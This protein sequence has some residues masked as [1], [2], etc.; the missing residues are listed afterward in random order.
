M[1]EKTLTAH[2]FPQNQL[3]LLTQA[4]KGSAKHD[5]G[6]AS[7]AVA[8]AGADVGAD[9]GAE[10]NTHECTDVLGAPGGLVLLLVLLGIL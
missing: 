1:L 4:D 8:D 3:E 2:I 5:H 6:E 9:T 10:P 7:D